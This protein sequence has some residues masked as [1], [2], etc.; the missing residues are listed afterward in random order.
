MATHCFTITLTTHAVPQQLIENVGS[1][2]I[3]GGV[4]FPVGSASLRGFQI[5]L[6]ACPTNTTAKNIYVGTKNMVVS[7]KVGCG[8]ALLTGSQPISLGQFG[9][10]E[11]V[12]DLWF[13]TDAGTDGTEKIMVTV[14]G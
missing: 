9:G 7:T 13:D 4:T 12:A 6:Q 11:D 14:V 8:M 10:A 3:I 5:Q 2:I 1:Q